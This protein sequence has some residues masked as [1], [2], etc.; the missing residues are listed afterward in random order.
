MALGNQFF[1]KYKNKLV[2]SIR[3]NYFREPIKFL[4]IIQEQLGDGKY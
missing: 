2:T 4:Y 3:D 1:L